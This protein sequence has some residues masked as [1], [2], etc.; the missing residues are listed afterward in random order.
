M[1]NYEIHEDTYAII[2]KK[3]GMT[4][5]IEK[6]REYD[7]SKEA[8]EVMDENCKYY[9]SSYKGRMEAAKELLKCSYKL[10]IIVEESNGLIFFPIKSTFLKDCC[11]INLNS[12]KNIEKVHDKTEITFKNDKKIVFDISK[13]SLEN[14]IYR[15]SK[16]ESIIFKRIY[17]KKRD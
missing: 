7:V 17:S 16:L 8:Y 10:P 3:K 14:Q 6:S 1:E 15:S 4:K 2:A 9:G 11:W 5:V 13:L 12:I